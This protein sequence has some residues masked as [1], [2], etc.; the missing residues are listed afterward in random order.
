MKSDTRLD[1][2]FD[3]LELDIEQDQGVPDDELEVSGFSIQT[4]QPVQEDTIT[5]Q[6]SNKSARQVQ[7]SAKISAATP[8]D[9]ELYF[10]P[11]M[12]QSPIRGLVSPVTF[13]LN[14]QEKLDRLEALFN[15]ATRKIE[16]AQSAMAKYESERDQTYFLKG[17]QNINLPTF[18]RRQE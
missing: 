15:N 17:F 2:A 10:S 16:L 7:S 11:V 9:P 3:L 8:I 12:T 18:E 1:R 14:P 6:K 5:P 4:Q 13:A